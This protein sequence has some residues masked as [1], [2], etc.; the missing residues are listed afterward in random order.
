MRGMCRSTGGIIGTAVMVVVL[1]LSQ[2]KAAG[3][4]TMF[5]AY[6]VLL[7]VAIPLTFLIPDMP[8]ASRRGGAPAGEGARS[9]PPTSEPV[10]APTGAPTGTPQTVSAATRADR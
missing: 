7:L 9:K 3:L 6:G 5:V 10:G 1:E 2:D 4:R 8:R